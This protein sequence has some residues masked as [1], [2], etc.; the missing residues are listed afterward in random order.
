MHTTTTLKPKTTNGTVP[1]ADHTALLESPA[2]PEPTKAAGQP[3]RRA[4]RK[5]V[6]TA[7]SKAQSDLELLGQ[8]ALEAHDRALTLD[9]YVTQLE[10]QLDV[11]RRLLGR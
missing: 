8:L 6:E 7:P 1:A 11:A 4:T 2:A 3:V 5:P 10:R 9:E